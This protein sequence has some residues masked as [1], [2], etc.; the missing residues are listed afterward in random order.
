MEWSIWIMFVCSFFWAF[1]IPC[2][3]FF[4]TLMWCYLLWLVAYGLYLQLTYEELRYCQ[5]GTYPNCT[6][7]L[8]SEGLWEWFV[9]PLRRFLVYDVLWKI[10][11][12][13]MASYPVSG[14]LIN[15]VTMYMM[16]FNLLLY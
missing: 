9:Y 4:A 7:Q 14:G 2:Y 13:W 5:T 16:Y 15:V 10:G 1:G 11:F 12:W 3:M 8:E 6:I